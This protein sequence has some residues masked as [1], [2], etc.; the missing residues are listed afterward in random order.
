MLWRQRGE[1]VR[2]QAERRRGGE[3]RKEAREGKEHTRLT[4]EQ[5]GERDTREG[6][7]DQDVDVT[8]R[9]LA[10][11]VAPHGAHDGVTRVS[12]PHARPELPLEL[13]QRPVDDHGAMLAASC[14]TALSFGA[15]L[16]S[17]S[18]CQRARMAC[19]ST[20]SQESDKA[21]LPSP[22]HQLLR[23]FD[24]G[25]GDPCVDL[26]A[27]NQT[28]PLLLR[29]AP[30]LVPLQMKGGQRPVESGSD[31]E[32]GALQSSHKVSPSE[33]GDEKYSTPSQSDFALCARS[34]FLDK[35]TIRALLLAMSICSLASQPLAPPPTLTFSICSVVSVP[36]RTASL[37]SLFMGL[38]T[39]AA[40]KPHTLDSV[41]AA[42]ASSFA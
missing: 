35:P 38:L 30:F 20:P 36:L 42:L 11:P 14:A 31:G 13:Q 6:G 29:Q 34:H 33:R 24:C 22:A 25:S 2:Q 4:G 17:L 21:R 40:P 7:E 39:V 41:C 32:P 3:G 15:P 5:L 10:P 9:L 27:V 18:R 8:A 12:A 28:R 26:V 1:V 37:K 16:Y 19:V 23:S